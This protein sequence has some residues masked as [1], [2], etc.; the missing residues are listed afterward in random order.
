M[1]GAAPDWTTGTPADAL[2]RAN[3]TYIDRLR[4]T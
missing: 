3:L 1:T 4:V 2:R